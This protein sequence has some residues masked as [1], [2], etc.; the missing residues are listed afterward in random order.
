MSELNNHIYNTYSQSKGASEKIVIKQV[1]N[2][3]RHF[4]KKIIKKYFP[5]EK[6]SRIYDLGAGLGS[7]VELAKSHGYK[8]V[9]GVDKSHDQVNA[10]TMISNSIIH[11]DAI[12]FVAGLVAQSVDLFILNDVIEHLNDDEIQS[13]MTSMNYKLKDNGRVLIHTNNACAPFFGMIRYGDITHLRAF[14]PDSMRQI[15][16]SFSYKSCQI[17]EM[18]P[19]VHGAISALRYI[20][21][22]LGAMLCKIYIAAET[23]RSFKN[24]SVSNNMIC[25]LKK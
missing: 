21:W 13:L 7:L 4:N 18:T 6:N 17:I 19:I 15:Q 25:I 5:R 9:Q 20:I 14:T 1:D 8:E 10:A 3:Q 22:V 23:G 2:L 11:D 24:I 12:N 16:R